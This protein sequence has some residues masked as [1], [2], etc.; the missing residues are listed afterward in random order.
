ME[1]FDLS[2]CYSKLDQDEIGRVLTRMIAIAFQGKHYLAVNPKDNLGRW[3]QYMDDSNH[4]EIIYTS[5]DL[6]TDVRFLIT[7]AYIEWLGAAWRQVKGIPMGL[8][9]SP[10][11]CDYY[12]LYWEMK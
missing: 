9:I 4:S 12:L 10:F 3:I 11:I 2:E 5:Q 8:G 7:N 1:T 6:K